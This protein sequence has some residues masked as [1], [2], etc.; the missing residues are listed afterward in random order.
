MLHTKV[1]HRSFPGFGEDFKGVFFVFFFFF[2]DQMVNLKCPMIHTKIQHICFLG[3]GE[4]F[5]CFSLT[6]Y[7]HD[8][9]LFQTNSQYSFN[10]LEAQMGQ[11]LLTWIRLIMDAT[12]CDGGHLAFS[13][14]ESMLF[15]E[16]QDCRYGR[17]LGYW[18]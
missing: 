17:N 1:Q 15:E 16:F 8:G 18:N 14:P 6:I 2:F 5:K 7:G 9:H 11:K 13:N 12:L 10:K 4:D 3:F